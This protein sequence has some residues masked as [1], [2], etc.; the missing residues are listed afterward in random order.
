M[1]LISDIVSHQLAILDLEGVK[2]KLSA[3]RDSVY[4]VHYLLNRG[5]HRTAFLLVGFIN[6]SFQEE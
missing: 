6:G 5:I 3:C 2:L 4:L 1:D